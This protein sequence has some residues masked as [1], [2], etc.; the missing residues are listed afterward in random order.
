MLRV[1]LPMS[2]GIECFQSYLRI[3]D[4]IVISSDYFSLGRSFLNYAPNFCVLIYRILF[5]LCFSNIFRFFSFLNEL[6]GHKSQHLENDQCHFSLP[7]FYVY[8][9]L[10]CIY[11]HFVLCLRYSFPCLYNSVLCLNYSVLC[12]NTM[13][14]ICTT[15]FC[16]YANLLFNRINNYPQVANYLIIVIESAL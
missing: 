11:T 6:I 1:E 15:L 10:L 12:F 13:F 2:F 14:C 4:L 7:P 3:T 5:V 16:V 9:I 8:T